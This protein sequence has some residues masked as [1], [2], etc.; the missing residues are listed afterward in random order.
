MFHRTEKFRTQPADRNEN[1][2]VLL[3]NR[4]PPNWLVM[5][6]TIAKLPCPI[7][8]VQHILARSVASWH[9]G[10]RSLETRWSENL[11]ISEV[12]QRRPETER[13]AG[14]DTTSRCLLPLRLNPRNGLITLVLLAPLQC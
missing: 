12:E 13:K 11:V 5:K 8:V 3:D 9:I 7:Q 6:D 4:S 10:K 2:V 14:D 1:V